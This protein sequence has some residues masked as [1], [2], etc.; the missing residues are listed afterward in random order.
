MACSSK[1]SISTFADVPEVRNSLR[2]DEDLRLRVDDKAE[3]DRSNVVEEDIFSGDCEWSE[4]CELR[5]LCVRREIDT[6][7]MVRVYGARKNVNV[8]LTMMPMLIFHFDLSS[9]QF[10][11]RGFISK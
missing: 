3:L 10:F 5:R 6:R 8:M 9:G 4:D 11:F 1:F 2:S 7:S